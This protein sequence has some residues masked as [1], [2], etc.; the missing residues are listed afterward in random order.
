MLFA[1]V[2]VILLEGQ[3]RWVPYVVGALFIAWSNLHGGWV[4]GLIVIGCYV[5]GDVIDRFRRRG[6][7]DSRDLVHDIKTL[8]AAIAGTLV[9]PYFLRLHRAVFVSLSD[10]GASRIIDE[11]RPPGFKDP[12]DLAFYV[13]LAVCTVMMIRSRRSVPGRWFVTFVMTAAFALRAGRNIA[14]FG[15][16]GLPIA[17]L[18]FAPRQALERDTPLHVQRRGLRGALF[19]VVAVLVLLVGLNRGKIAGRTVIQGDVNPARFPVAATLWLHRSGENVRLLTTWTWSG[20]F[21]YAS[22]GGRVFFDPLF[23]PPGTL[24]DFGRVLLVQPGW[25]DVVERSSVNAFLLPVGARLADSLARNSHWA[26]SYR[27]AR[28]VVYGQTHP[29]RAP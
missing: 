9:N 14:F 17:A 25:R 16:V 29:S 18:S 4:F 22:P 28:A 10:V 12:I 13:A 23:F 15:L 27:D 24:D 3:A 6:L 26:L 21:A 1:V 11:Y 8:I 5:T 2:L 19:T 7:Y 20:Y